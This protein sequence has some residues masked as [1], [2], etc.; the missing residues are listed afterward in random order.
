ME[1]A[2]AALPQ[3][4]CHKKVWALKIK[5]IV[6]APPQPEG[7]ESDPGMRS[8]VVEPEHV[9]APINVSGAFMQKHSPQPGGYWVRYEDGYESFSPA[10]AFEEGYSLLDTGS[11]GFLNPSR[12]QSKSQGDPTTFEQELERLINRFSKENGSDTP[13][14]IVTAYLLRC[15]E[16]YDSTVQARENWYG[17]RI[18]SIVGAISPESAPSKPT[19]A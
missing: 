13:D 11:S 12:E 6:N 7:S 19:D 14:F 2:S 8:L 15:L 1:Q 4:Q 9:F 10:K 5:S 18:H 3:Y 17:R 16:T